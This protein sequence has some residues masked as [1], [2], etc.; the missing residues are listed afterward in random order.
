MHEAFFFPQTVLEYGLM[1]I[2]KFLKLTKRKIALGIVILIAGF[3]FFPQITKSNQPPLQF[4][5]VE[6][7]DIESAVSSSG[8]LTGQ[9]SAVLKFKSGGRLAYINVKPGDKVFAGQVIAGL[10]TQDLSIALQQARNTLTEKQATLDKIH[11]E[12]K[13]HDADETFTQ[14][15]TRTV[16]EVAANNAYD[17]VKAAERDFQDV[18]IIAP[19][20]GLVTQ[21]VSLSG[22]NVSSGDVI[23]QVVD[24]SR[25][26]FE[27]DVDEADII[28]VV[29][30]QKALI[31][32]DAYPD[33][34]FEGEV[35]EIQP[36]IKTTSSGANVV[37][38]KIKMSGDIVFINGLSGQAQ[39][40]TASQKSAL[41]IPQEALRDDNSVVL[42]ANNELKSQ[43][44]EAGIKSDTHVEIK[45]GLN[46]NDRILLNPPSAGTVLHQASS[47]PLSRLM[48]TLG[49]GP[50]GPAVRAR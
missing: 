7:E 31:S 40:I 50:R 4:A 29:L 24:N 42:R 15:Q 25:L 49:I 27:T 12:V 30:G 43:K 44:V 41:T 35:S 20:N 8:T 2:K 21:A 47:N 3:L 18:V 36:Q 22:V 34:V 48:R 23:A 46:E 6:R 10:D 5:Q 16:A 39:I 1:K 19:I 37:S 9:N 38:V 32:F 26:V 11:D 14:R 45:S 17:G 28:N 13:G 33:K